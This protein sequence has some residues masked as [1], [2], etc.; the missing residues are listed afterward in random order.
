[1]ER[2]AD[3]HISGVGGEH[4]NGENL[5]MSRK[6]GY[7]LKEAFLPYSYHPLLD[8]NKKNL[9]ANML[10][11]KYKSPLLDLLND[12]VPRLKAI[13]HA[14]NIATKLND[15]LGAPGYAETYNERFRALFQANVAFY[16]LHVVAQ[17]S[18]VLVM[19]YNDRELMTFI[20]TCHPSSRELRRLQLALL[21]RYGLAKEIPID[22]SHLTQ[23]KPY[24]AHKFMRTIRMVLNIGLHKKVPIIQKGNPPR[25]RAFKYFDHNATEY[26]EY[27]NEMISGCS[28]LDKRRTERYLKVVG[29]VKKFNFYSHHREAGNILLLLRLAY[30]ERM[31]QNG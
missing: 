2:G 19:P 31:F 28:F 12:S 6:P 15:F 17:N 22:T 8:F 27:V 4:L 30:A 26:R 14:E 13:D 16:A 23:S 1:M 5:Y 24:I 25:H 18:D 7:V 11:S 9:I 29:E 3:F 21:R 10:Y 20:S